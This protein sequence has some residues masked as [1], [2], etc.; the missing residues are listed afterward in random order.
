VGPTIGKISF[1]LD[2]GN[3]LDMENCLIPVGIDEPSESVH[4]RL[5]DVK[6]FVIVNTS[7]L[8][9]A[10]YGNRHVALSRYR[11]WEFVSFKF[12]EAG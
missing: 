10:I 7:P 3:L 6:Q 9:D 11:E 1:L 8:G 2:T 5:E 12:L 4:Y